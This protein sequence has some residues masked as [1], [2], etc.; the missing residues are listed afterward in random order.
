MGRE[1][2]EHLNPGMEEALDARY[3]HLLP[4]MALLHKLSVGIPI[5]NPE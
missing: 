1:L 5:M 3:G 2:S 4:E